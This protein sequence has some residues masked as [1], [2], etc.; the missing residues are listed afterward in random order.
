[1]VVLTRADG[2]RDIISSVET[3]VKLGGSGRGTDLGGLSSLLVQISAGL[4]VRRRAAKGVNSLDQLAVSRT[5]LS[6]SHCYVYTQISDYF[7]R[8]CMRG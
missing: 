2:A 8:S 4:L 3:S 5:R 1:M 7:V 6:D